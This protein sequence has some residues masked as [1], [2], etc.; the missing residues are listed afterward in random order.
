MK[1]RMRAGKHTGFMN[2][3][4]HHIIHR[5][6]DS[7]IKRRD[8]LFNGVT[9]GIVTPQGREIVTRGLVHPN[10][11]VLDDSASYDLAS[12]TKAFVAILFHILAG[13]RLL[14]G[15]T[16]ESYVHEHLKIRG[17][18]TE[19]LQVRHLLLY[20]TE[21]AASDSMARMVEKGEDPITLILEQ[22]LAAAP[23]KSFHY[24]N[25]CALVLGLLLEA[26]TRRALPVLMNREIFGPLGMKD[27]TFF[28]SELQDSR[29]VR[30][31]P[32]FNGLRGV[33][34]DESAR[35][36]LCNHKKA[37]G[38]AGLFSTA[39]DMLNFMAMLLDKGLAPNGKRVMQHGVVKSLGANQIEGLGEF[40]NG[41]GCWSCFIRGFDD[42]AVTS[43][44]GYFKSGHTGS[45]MVV[46]P[47]DQI[48]FFIG[49]DFLALCKDPQKKKPPLFHW[50]VKLISDIVRARREESS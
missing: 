7:A 1:T 16:P 41:V 8:P 37:I 33:V 25:H 36:Y 35:H 46:L 19:E 3:G 47:R 42:V 9:V 48:A 49:T 43:P 18:Y 21:F 22:G 20:L 15:M 13:K 5:Q 12:I 14:D 27:T 50:M 11:P 40:G 45:I 31:V 26:V 6:A 29:L 10:G 4:Y 17:L 44:G 34:Y 39:S 23:G 28:P 30:F 2:L 38:S 32:T 24:N